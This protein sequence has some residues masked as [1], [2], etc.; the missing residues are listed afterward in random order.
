MI[1]KSPPKRLAGVLGAPR[2]VAT[3]GDTHDDL[4]RTA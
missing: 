2:P 3:S 4:R 1:E